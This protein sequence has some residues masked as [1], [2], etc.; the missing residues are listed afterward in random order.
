[1]GETICGAWKIGDILRICCNERRMKRRDRLK[2]KRI[3]N[4][5][6][7]NANLGDESMNSVSKYA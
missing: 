2:A 7:N 4:L 5:K 6:L 1:V 3:R